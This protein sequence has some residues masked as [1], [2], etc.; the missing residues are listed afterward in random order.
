LDGIAYRRWSVPVAAFLSGSKGGTGK[1]TLCV[2]AALLGKK[3]GLRS[4]I[5]D[6]GESGNTT[7]LLAKSVDPPFF[8]DYLLGRAAWGDT[9]VEVE[10]G[11][12]LAP[13]PPDFSLED[14][15]ALLGVDRGARERYAAFFS[16]LEGHVDIVYI[17]FP[18]FPFKSYSHLLSP[19]DTV[20][21]VV[22]PD[23][24]SYTAALHTYTGSAF[25]VPVLNKYHPA[26]TYWKDLLEDSFNE[27]IILVPFDVT[28]SFL[29][30]PNIGG[31]EKYVDSATR[32]AVGELVTRLLARPLRPAVQ[33]YKG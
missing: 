5:V 2:L 6:L 27:E 18:A 28:L 10:P 13:S 30:R 1:T 21:L 25:V 31:V 7:S 26:A 20:V 11:L 15:R 4:L 16:K 17:D 22:N 32:R 24:L 3:R 8:T 12:Y 29:L 33:P 19:V 9:I 14:V 23:P